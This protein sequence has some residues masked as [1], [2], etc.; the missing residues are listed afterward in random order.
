[1]KEASNKIT[2]R[3]RATQNDPLHLIST[4]KPG[5]QQEEEHGLVQHVQLEHYHRKVLRV[6]VIVN[7]PVGNSE[8]S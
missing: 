4:K 1:M 5:G 6:R 8:S 7:G 2:Q 3:V